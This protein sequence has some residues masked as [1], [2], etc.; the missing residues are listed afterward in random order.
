MSLVI[1]SKKPTPNTTLK[2]S[3]WPQV[4][5]PQKVHGHMPHPLQPG[6]MIMWAP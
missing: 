6:S 2:G 3:L 5:G 4:Q 1:L